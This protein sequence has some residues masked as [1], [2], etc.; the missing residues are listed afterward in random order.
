MGRLLMDDEPRSMD[1]AAFDDF[2]AGFTAAIY[3]D[4]FT[5]KRVIGNWEDDAPPLSQVLL[6]A[7]V[8]CVALLGDR[9]NANGRLID[10]ELPVFLAE[11]RSR[12]THPSNEQP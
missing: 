11:L 5:I 9:A 1:E 8:A 2:A 12:V 4:A 7:W 6:T 3:G 10:D